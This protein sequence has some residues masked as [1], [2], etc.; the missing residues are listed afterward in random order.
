MKNIIFLDDG[1]DFEEFLIKDGYVDD[2][3]SV[4][5]VL[6]DKTYL[7]KYI[8]KR[9][10]TETSPHKTNEKCEKC[11]QN[12]YKSDKR[13]YS[14]EEGYKRALLDCL[15]SMKTEYSSAIAPI[16]IENN[17]NRKIPSKILELFNEVKSNMSISLEANDEN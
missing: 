12:I 11:K 5:E 16:I 8:E 4:I 1:A 2:L 3:V 14:G 17:P 9:D 15:G 6:K 7:D 13:D 10:K